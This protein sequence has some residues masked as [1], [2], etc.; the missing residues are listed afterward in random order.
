MSPVELEF[1]TVGVGVPKI[2]QLWS[3][4]H[5]GFSLLRSRE[6]NRPITDRSAYGAKMY[7]DREPQSS[8]DVKQGCVTNPTPKTGAVD[9]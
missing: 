4:Q 3:I 1:P 5:L 8:E 2:R 6:T 9:G 7:A